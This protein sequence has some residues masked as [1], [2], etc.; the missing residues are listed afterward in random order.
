MT[1]SHPRGSHCWCGGSAPCQRLTCQPSRDRGQRFQR[2]GRRGRGLSASWA[3]RGRVA[4]PPWLRSP[5]REPRG[6]G[7][8][9]EYCPGPRNHSAAQL[10]VNMETQTDRQH[11]SLT[12]S[13]QVLTHR[14]RDSGGVGVVDVLK[15]APVTWKHVI[16]PDTEVV[17][18]KPWRK[19]KLIKK[20]SRDHN[21]LHTSPRTPLRHSPC[22]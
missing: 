19:S 21:I 11:S 6:C 2:R 20:T 15:L 8:P 1:D 9:G 22:R 13:S 16:L 18:S 3:C 14:L 4:A 17:V 12:E 10:S 7:P 5:L